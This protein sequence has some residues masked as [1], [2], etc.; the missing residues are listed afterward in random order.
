MSN[1]GGNIL[2]TCGLNT[3]QWYHRCWLFCAKK[4]SLGSCTCGDF[5]AAHSLCPVGSE[6]LFILNNKRCG[7]VEPQRG[8]QRTSCIMQ[9]LTEMLLL[10]GIRGKFGRFHHAGPGPSN[11]GAIT[12]T[13]QARGRQR[14]SLADA[15]K[16]NKSDYHIV[17][18]CDTPHPSNGQHQR[19]ISKPKCKGCSW[20]YKTGLKGY[21]TMLT[22]SVL[23]T[24]QVEYCCPAMHANY[25]EPH[26]TSARHHETV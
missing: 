21:L 19:A 7:C 9:C 24:V 23:N 11:Y 1:R 12:S 22:D 26:F 2:C 4:H 14:V 3:I 10:A 20:V 16:M 15:S 13:K 17:T 5:A 25:Y 6:V 8:E 18:C